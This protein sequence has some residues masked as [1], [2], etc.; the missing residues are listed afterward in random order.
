MTLGFEELMALALI[1]CIS[2]LGMPSTLQKQ[3]KA[4]VR[5]A[6]SSYPEEFTVKV[7]QDY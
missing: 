4:N 1:L 6:N 3:I 2:N 5:E 7:S